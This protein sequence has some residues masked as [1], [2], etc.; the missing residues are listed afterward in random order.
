LA[1]AGK[2]AIEIAALSAATTNEFLL[3]LI[4]IL[5]V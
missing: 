3:A 1:R 5:P 2:A 4:M